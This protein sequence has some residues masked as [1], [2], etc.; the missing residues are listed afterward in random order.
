MKVCEKYIIL[1]SAAA[2]SGGTGIM[3]IL[4]TR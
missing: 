2:E 1:N 3:M 4:F